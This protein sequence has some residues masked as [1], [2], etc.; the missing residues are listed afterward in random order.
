MAGIN[1]T[2]A[3]LTQDA[4]AARMAQ[5][6]EQPVTFSLPPRRRSAPWDLPV[7]SA[8]EP[9]TRRTGNVVSR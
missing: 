3:A 9:P 1:R 8:G 2:A 5:P 7:E 6:Y 4:F